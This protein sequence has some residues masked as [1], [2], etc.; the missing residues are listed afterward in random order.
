MMKIISVPHATLRATAQPVIKLTD[1][2]WQ[3]ST[4]LPKTLLAQNNPPGVGLAAPQVNQSWRMFVTHVA[5]DNDES[6]PSQ[7]VLYINPVITKTSATP[8]LGPRAGEEVLE[9]CLS[10]PNLYGPV[11]R[12]SWVE[13]EYQT[14]E[15]DKLVNRRLRASDFAAR[16]IQ[17]ELDHLNGVLFTDYILQYD[18]PLF[19]GT[20]RS[21]KLTE[22][23]R[24]VALGF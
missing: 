22:I 17:H 14:V 5:L 3:L 8:V 21:S 16:V 12:W 7:M 20:S 6:A 9:G 24:S 18:L 10:I 13:L 23:D 2:L 4:E 1:E 19:R 15:G 11:P